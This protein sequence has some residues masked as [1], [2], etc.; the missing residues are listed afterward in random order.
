MCYRALL[1]CFLWIDLV[2]VVYEFGL[3]I[4]PM[5]AGVCGCGVCWR[6]YLVAMGCLFE[7]GWGWWFAV[8]AIAL[9]LLCWNALLV[10]LLRLLIDFGGV[11]GWLCWIRGIYNMCGILYVLLCLLY[12]AVLCV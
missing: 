3:W 2:W 7:I 4:L 1:G 10:G 5:L 8:V 6:L 9:C 11:L 12:V